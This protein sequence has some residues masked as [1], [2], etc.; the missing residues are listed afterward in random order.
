MID[1]IVR[2]KLSTWIFTEFR[3]NQ[4]NSEVYGLHSI[5][6]NLREREYFPIDRNSMSVHGGDGELNP[7]P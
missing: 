5:F 4:T 2:K 3:I 1:H 6:I 7:K